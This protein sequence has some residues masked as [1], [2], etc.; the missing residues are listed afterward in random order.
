M[1]QNRL[2]FVR[3][4]DFWRKEQ[5]GY[6]ALWIFAMVLAVIPVVFIL[7]SSFVPSFFGINLNQVSEA[8]E[9]WIPLWE[10]R[11][12]FRTIEIDFPVYRQ[13]L[14]FSATPISPEALPVWL[15]VIIQA[16]GWSL[17]LTATTRLK[18]FWTYLFFL[19]YALFLHFTGVASH[20]AGESIVLGYGIE[21]VWIIGGLILAY[22]RQVEW[23]NWKLPL[24][25][26]VLFVWTLAPMVILGM[27][28]SW[29]PLHDVMTRTYPF[30]L[31]LLI[32]FVMFVA[33]EPINLVVYFTTNRRQPAQR[34]STNMVVISLVLVLVLEL[35]W[36]LNA[37]AVVDLGDIFIR[38]LYVFLLAALVMPVTA[39]N[40]FGQVRKIFPRSAFLSVLLISWTLI[41]LSFVAVN[42]SVMDPL[43]ILV[44]ERLI[45]VLFFGVGLGY[46]IF[47]FSNH[48]PLFKR[49]IHLY[50]LM[51]R[52]HRLGLAV[53]WLIGIIF[54]VVAEG[55]QGW[56]GIRL[57][58]HVA[59]NHAADQ[60]LLQGNAEEAEVIYQAALNNSP[61]SPKTNYNLASISV[62]NPKRLGETI[63]YYQ[64]ATSV[65]D[66][67]YARING[68]LLLSVSEAKGEAI[69]LLSNGEQDGE[70]AAE[71]LNNLGV[72]LRQEGQ[73]DS[74]VVVF[75][76]ALLLSP[77]LAAAAV[78]LAEV[79]RE[80][81]RPEE[82]LSFYQ[83]AIESKEL[84]APVLAAG[85]EFELATGSEL[86]LPTGSAD[87]QDPLL[88]YHEML[89]RWHQGD[90]LD[91]E[92]VQQLASTSSEQG[93]IILD[94]LRQFAQDSIDYAKSKTEYLSSSFPS[95]AAGLWN[96]LGGAYLDRSVPEMAEYCFHQAGESG[97]GKGQFLESQV[98]LDQGKLDSALVRLGEAR[99]NDESLWEPVSKELAMLLLAQGQDVY[100][101]LEHDLTS[102]EF[103]DWMRVAK[104]ADSTMQYI[105]ALNAYRKAQ[106]LDSS[107]VAPYLELAKLYTGVRDSLAFE[108][109]EA[110][111]QLVDRND[112]M[113]KLGLM[114][115]KLKFGDVEGAA[116]LLNELPQDIKSEYP[117]EVAEVILAQGDTSSALALYQQ[118]YAENILD[119]RAIVPLFDLAFSTENLA[120][121]NELITTALEYNR[122]NPELW[123]R[124]ALI[125]RSWRFPEDAGFGAV[126][127]IDLSRNSAFKEKIATEF[128][129]EIRGLSK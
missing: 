129:D 39:L 103:D 122:M 76:K 2:P 106:K 25:W 109:L 38:P 92:A 12:I 64:T 57:F 32:P 104:Y 51:G 8:T 19:L 107:A 46:T 42:L 29:I 67:P 98:M 18:T 124:Y 99:I 90:T 74:A 116:T 119:T 17:L 88:T 26:A 118:M 66:F 108:N 61:V 3:L 101:G 128:A 113:L 117:A 115:S 14:T 52:G 53:V 84:S 59:A 54:L 93:P 36:L 22:S 37:L 73:A 10:I 81:N 30:Q 56:R 13:S 50:Y 86:T 24:T 83:L 70:V 65:L 60:Q 89:H 7:L 20:L 45:A 44:F 79:Y 72:L 68:A 111:F 58:A 125:S 35:L 121:A 11:H 112:P 126:Q 62:R 16:A 23:I 71:R 28:E 80:N 97:S 94:L 48:L 55:Y 100:A 114:G 102:L 95:R 5:T 6:K 41:S 27:N 87:F 105:P 43:F 110:G 31:I 1:D 49:K 82:A 78:N 85:L 69:K 77:Q 34:F 21:F 91:W 123:Y 15:F 33:K 120:E 40:L 63:Q 75:Q 47:L 127:A 4:Y 96:V 9:S